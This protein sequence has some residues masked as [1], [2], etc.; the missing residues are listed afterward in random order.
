MNTTFIKDIAERASKTFLQF[1]LG[2]WLLTNGLLNTDAATPSPDMFDTLFTS[3]NLKAGVV[4]L[5]L[6]L[7]TNFVTKPFGRDGN[8]ASLVVKTVE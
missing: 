2:F 8:S 3:D 5:A 4:G 7:A 6:S 1:Y